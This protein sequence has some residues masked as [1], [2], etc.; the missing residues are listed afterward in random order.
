MTSRILASTVAAVLLCCSPL[1]AQNR[2]SLIGL[3]LEDPAWSLEAEAIEYT[4]ETIETL[5]GDNVTSVLDYGLIGASQAEFGSSDGNVGVTFYEM[6]DSTASFG[7]FA[8]ERDW[9][10]PDFEPAVV[11]AESYRTNDTLVFWQANYVVRLEGSPQKTDALGKTIAD[12]VIGRSRKANVSLLLPAAGRVGESEKYILTPTAF[13]TITGLDPAELGFNNSVEVAVAAYTQ[14]TGSGRLAM[15]LYPTQQLAERHAEAW[16]ARFE[17]DLP[18]GRSGPLF[19]IL[20]DSDS[21]ELSESI[22][23]VLS[24]QSE[25][26]WTETL[27]DPL[28]LPHMI[29]TIFKF[30]GIALA[31]TLIVGLVFGGFRIYMKT[32]YPGFVFG[33]PDD[34]E[35]IQLKLD[36]SFTVKALKPGRPETAQ[37]E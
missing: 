5:V 17:G 36:Q 7:L 19:A 15:F 13:E 18:S 32:H 33:G 25:V 24:Y 30:I 16:L 2:E 11:G 28:T 6:A 1:T 22:M 34:V 35:F 4:A 26:T 10:R 21:D 29:L 8:L 9:Q 27:P 23:S 31:F 12:H 37:T 14:P 20:L 3:I